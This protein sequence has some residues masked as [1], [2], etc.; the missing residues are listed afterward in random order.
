VYGSEG[1]TLHPQAGKRDTRCPPENNPEV[2]QRGKNQGS[3]NTRRAKENSRER[4]KTPPRNTGRE[5]YNNRLR[6]SL[7]PHSERR[8]RTANRGDKGIRKRTG[9]ASPNPQGH[10]FWIEREQEELPETPR[11]GC[12]RR[13]LESYHHL[14]GQ[15]NP[16]RLQNPRILL[17]ATRC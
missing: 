3:P 8:F 5:R 15:A 2:G 13:S 9:L 11:T 7:Q 6:K 14:S 17:P 10:R 1:K 12:E 16:L 4:D